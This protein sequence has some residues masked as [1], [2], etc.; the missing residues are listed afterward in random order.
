M[1]AA[2]APIFVTVKALLPVATD[3]EVVE[4]VES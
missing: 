4:V 1:P 3:R 2:K